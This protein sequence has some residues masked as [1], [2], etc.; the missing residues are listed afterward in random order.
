MDIARIYAKFTPDTDVLYRRAMAL[1]ARHRVLR[2]HHVL[3]AAVAVDFDKATVDGARPNRS[4]AMKAKDEPKTCEESEDSPVAADLV[5]LLHSIRQY[6]GHLS[7]LVAGD[8]TGCLDTPLTNSPTMRRV[9]QS[10]AMASP[11]LSC[12]RPWHLVKHALMRW[13]EEVPA[14]PAAVVTGFDRAPTATELEAII[15]PA[16]T[17]IDLEALRLAISKERDRDRRAWLAYKLYYL[18]ELG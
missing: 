3:K 5:G 13:P 8:R 6:A 15:G 1:A 7:A 2:V 9:L 10:A 17:D 14:G 4:D 11:Y 12:L 16:I 18:L